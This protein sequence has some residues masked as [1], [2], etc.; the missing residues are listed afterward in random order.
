MIG[1]GKQLV[2]PRAVEGMGG[3][4]RGTIIVVRHGENFTAAMVLRPVIEHVT[5]FAVLFSSKNL[6]FS[7]ARRIVVCGL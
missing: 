7:H 2:R 3:A 4:W 6:I 5:G 1:Y